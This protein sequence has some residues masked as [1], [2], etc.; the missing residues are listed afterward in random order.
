MLANTPPFACFQRP[1]FVE[2]GPCLH[3]LPLFLHLAHPSELAG[4]FELKRGFEVP[5]QNFRANWERSTARRKSVTRPDFESPP[6]TRPRAEAAIF[7]P[8]P[9]FPS[10][11][12]FASCLFR[13]CHDRQFPWPEFY[14]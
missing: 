8:R 10:S 12:S 14:W 9:P 2:I 5:G 6:W 7:L 13:F 4:V 3:A 1:G 11:M